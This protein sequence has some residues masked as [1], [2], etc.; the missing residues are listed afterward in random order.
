MTNTRF[1]TKWNALQLIEDRLTLLKKAILT[2][3][4][5]KELVLFLDKFIRSISDQNEK[6]LILLYIKKTINQF[7]RRLPQDYVMAFEEELLLN[8]EKFLEEQSEY[9]PSNWVDM[10]LDFIFQKTH[11]NLN[12]VALKQIHSS[13]KTL[14]K[15]L[16]TMNEVLALLKISKATLDRRRSEGMPCTKKGKKIYFKK[17]EISNWL[18]KKDGQ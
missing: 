2:L 1:I 11:L 7:P 3:Y 10:E 5:N 9:D 12:E 16:L 6:R 13:E 17:T 8:S 4:V 14:E 15:E 18:N